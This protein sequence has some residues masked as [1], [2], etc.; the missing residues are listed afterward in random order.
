MGRGIDRD[1]VLQLEVVKNGV[2][3]SNIYVKFWHD[4]SISND[5]SMAAIKA[6]AEGR[7]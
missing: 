2:N 6:V 4:D 5:T 1:L 7:K 3:R